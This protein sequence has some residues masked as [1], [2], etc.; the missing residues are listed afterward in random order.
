MKTQSA[1]YFRGK[2]VP[3]GNASRDT[4]KGGGKGKDLVIQNSVHTHTAENVVIS[5]TKKA[6]PA[7]LEMVRQANSAPS[8]D[9]VNS[10]FERDKTLEELT[11]RVDKA[12]TKEETLRAIGDV[13]RRQGELQLEASQLLN[14][15]RTRNLLLNVIELAKQGEIDYLRQCAIC[16]TI[17]FAGRKDQRGCSPSCLTKLRKRRW[18]R[19]Y[20]EAKAGERR[21]YLKKRAETVKRSPKRP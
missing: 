14:Q 1:K 7:L 12:T 2:N 17:F 18:K 15:I 13:Q 4:F 20:D 10:I 19:N 5:L 9:V 6:S 8:L 16:E 3:V 21:G 11:S